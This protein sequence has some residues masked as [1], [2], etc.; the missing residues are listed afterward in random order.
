M[1]EAPDKLPAAISAL[2]SH[3]STQYLPKCLDMISAEEVIRRVELYFAGG[4]IDYLTAEQAAAVVDLGVGCD[5]ARD[6][7]K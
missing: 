6:N 3:L 1:R 4:A 5:F 2:N 7:T